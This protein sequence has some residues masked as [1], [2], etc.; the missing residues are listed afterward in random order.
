M[1]RMPE[2][3]EIDPIT[4]PG[5]EGARRATGGPGPVIGSRA[6]DPDPEVPAKVERLSTAAPSSADAPALLVIHPARCGWMAVTGRRTQPARYTGGSRRIDAGNAT[7]G[8]DERAYDR[9][10]CGGDVGRRVRP[11]WSRGYRGV[12][13]ER[14]GGGRVN[15]GAD[16]GSR[17][18]RGR[19]GSNGSART[20]PPRTST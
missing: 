13:R 9:R 8:S 11:G 6:S 18:A 20:G 16:G 10:A 3:V 5:A 4:G 1:P 7:G 17:C 2:V 14:R 19:A 12:G 15:P